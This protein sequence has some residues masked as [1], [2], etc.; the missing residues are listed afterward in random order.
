MG[1]LN[2]RGIDAI[3]EKYRALSGIGNLHCHI[4]RHVFFDQFY[5]FHRKGGK[6]MFNTIFTGNFYKKCVFQL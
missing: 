2:R 6:R 5:F 3:F 1:A 4:L